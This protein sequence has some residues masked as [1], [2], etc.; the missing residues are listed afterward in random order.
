MAKLKNSSATAAKSAQTS[1]SASSKRTDAGYTSATP[2]TS[3]PSV[4]ESEFFTSQAPYYRIDQAAELLGCSSGELL[5]LGATGYVEVMAPILGAVSFELGRAHSIA[6]FV[7]IDEILR[8]DFFS[9]DR[10]IISRFDLAHIEAL[11][12]VI[13]TSFRCPGKAEDVIRKWLSEHGELTDD[14][15]YRVLQDRLAS[16]I[17]EAREGMQFPKEIRS[18][19]NAPSLF[20]GE[21]G[22]A[23]S[24]TY[25][26]FDPY[27]GILHAKRAAL[28][29]LWTV[30]ENAVEEIG[31]VTES[32]LFISR[33]EIWRLYCGGQ[34]QS[35]AL[36]LDTKP[37][38]RASFHGNEWRFSNEREAVL[39]VAIYAASRNPQVMETATKWADAIE[40]RW[41]QVFR[42]EVPPEVHPDELPYQLD[43]NVARRCR[44]GPIRQRA[45]IE[46]LLREVMMRRASGE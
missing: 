37:L 5:T 10:V 6:P 3:R 8:A 2:N 33:A 32:H 35:P 1:A 23:P 17:C 39:R 38:D 13:P 45:G 27:V 12:W 30:A 9:W 44:E 36:T 43:L 4:V 14:E 19:E 40:Q 25:P 24:A 41:T 34:S 16:Q 21:N 20:T 7:E 11:G 31:R 26:P 22:Q 15:R 42:E 18:V 29:G 28:Y 46:K